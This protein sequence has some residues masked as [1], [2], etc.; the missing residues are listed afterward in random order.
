MFAD[1]NKRRPFPY[2]N[3]DL[4]FKGTT[5]DEHIA[6]LA[7]ILQPIGKSGLQVSAKKSP[8]CQEFIKY[9]GFKFNRTGYQPL[10]LHV[11]AIL[12]INPPE[13]IKKIHAFHGMINF[14]KSH[15]PRCPEICEPII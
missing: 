12:R 13:N 6:I 10:P 15:I 4:H 11:S 8:F 1:M 2:I 5:F 7:E 3:N 14:I 9:L